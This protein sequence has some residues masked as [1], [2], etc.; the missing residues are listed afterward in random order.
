[1]SRLTLPTFDGTKKGSTQ[2]W[3]QKLDTYFSLSPMA[4]DEAIKFAILHLEGLAHEWWH[5]DLVTQGFRQITTY[6]EFTQ[7]LTE[8]FDRKDPESYFQELTRL[9]KIGT[10]EDYVVD[11]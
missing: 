8:R 2:A 6:A 4:E 3:I 7:K 9:K 10:A 1:M 5:H 11:F